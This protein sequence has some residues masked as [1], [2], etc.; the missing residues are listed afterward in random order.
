M[1][2]LQTDDARGPCLACI[3]LKKECVYTQE[4][5]KSL[6][7]SQKE[8]HSP[9]APSTQNPSQY[10]LPP[11][12]YGFST[13]T[14]NRMSPDDS[15]HSFTA[16]G[17]DPREGQQPHSPIPPTAPFSVQHAAQDGTAVPTQSIPSESCNVSNWV[18]PV[19]N[20]GYWAGDVGG[21]APEATFESFQ[22]D[23]DST[24]QQRVGTLRIDEAYLQWC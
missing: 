4:G 23:P 12:T 1:R 10:Q 13:E 2:C 6:S 21:S 15:W 11:S 19:P 20:S 16:I 9:P 3:R 24:A 22:I 7:T 8:S 18:E 17:N 5:L 14:L